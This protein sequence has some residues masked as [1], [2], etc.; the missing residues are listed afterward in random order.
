[1]KILSVTD[2]KGSAIWRLAMGVKKNL[3]HHQIDVID[4][5]PKRPDPEQ[6]QNFEQLAKKADIISYEYWKTAELLLEEY[7][8]YSDKPKIL[9]HYNP[10]NV[11]EKDWKDYDLVT[12]CNKEMS[13]TLP[14]ATYIPLAID[15]EKFKFKRN[16]TE[17][18]VVQMVSSRIEGKKGVLPVAQACKELGYKLLLIG[19]ISDREY[20]DKIMA[21]GVVEFREQVSEEE[22]VKSYHE[23]RVHVCNSVSNF[24][25]GTMPILEAMS[26]GL[27]VMTRKIGH[28]P[29]LS[30]D[31]NMIVRKGEPEDLGDLKT[32]LKR[33]VEMKD[34]E[35]RDMREAAWKTAKTKNEFRRARQVEELFYRVLYPHNDLVSVII[36]TYNRKEILFEVLNALVMDEWPNKEIV[37]VDDGSNDGTDKFIEMYRKEISKYPITIK[38]LNTGTPDEYNLSHARNLGIIYAS[39]NVLVFLDDRY[40]PKPKFIHKLLEKLGNKKWVYGNKGY[41]KGFVENVS[42]IHRDE[43][44]NAG[45]FN[46]SV[47]M[48]GFQTQELRTRFQRQGFQLVPSEAEVEI[49]VDTKNKFK[50]KSEIIKSKDILWALK[51]E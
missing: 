18:K 15:V 51:L 43:I 20:F 11:L 45:M 10:Y 41:D 14:T 37:V 19:S 48:Y 38:Y 24:E 17:N 49:L 6:Y 44:I 31:I 30:N 32:N 39:G 47:K 2:K 13:K 9:W 50:K 36:P 27:V 26:T 28:V 5:H 8:E 34:E 22:L 46:E 29:E 25:S 4:V 42:C 21:T 16:P 1:M 12:V 7:P 3:P 40:K 35:Y 33:V 23:A